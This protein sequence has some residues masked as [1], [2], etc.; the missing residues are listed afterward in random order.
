ME[1]PEKK[2][3]YD[4]VGSRNRKTNGQTGERQKK[5]WGFLIDNLQEFFPVAFE[6]KH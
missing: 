2:N 6:V 1:N 3:E 4:N 5:M